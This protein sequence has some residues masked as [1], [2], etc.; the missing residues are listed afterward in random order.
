VAA[1]A[2]AAVALAA[3][4]E[5]AGPH[6]ANDLYQELQ[7]EGVTLAGKRIM[8]PAPMLRD[9]LTAAEER[10]ALRRLAGSEGGVD[11]LLRNSVTAPV[12]VRLRDEKAADGTLIRIAD[13]GFAVH[14]T[15]DEIDPARLTG[16]GDDSKP[17]EAGNMRFTNRF[18]GDDELARCGI[19]K[20][21][22][23]LEWYSHSK[24]DLLDRIRVETTSRGRGTRS[25]GS[26][27]IASR[28]DPRFD[29]DADAPNRWVA[30]DRGGKGQPLGEPRLYAG[31]ASTTRISRLASLL[32][33]LWVEGH[34]AFAE[35]HAW[36]EGAPILRSKITLV[37]QDQ[38]R[39]LRRELA[40]R[41]SGRPS[42]R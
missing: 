32:G 37:A 39:R 2:L 42:D 20:A 17:V 41:R 8:F 13:V 18:L 16:R 9:D 33:A 5:P 4:P 1:F 30:L 19:R 28:T 26:W 11:E 22:P 24:A 36:F 34:V 7:G 15:L 12:V 3:A 14:A 27:I 10:A 29:R 38:V 25:E 35:P 21:D 23:K 31:G 40:T 6:A